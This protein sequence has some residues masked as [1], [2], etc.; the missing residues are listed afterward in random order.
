MMVA[1]LLVLLASCSQFEDIQDQQLAMQ[2]QNNLPVAGFARSEG[3][4]YNPD[5]SVNFG[6]STIKTARLTLKV[7]VFVKA[8][9]D[10]RKYV[11]DKKGFVSR[12]EQKGESEDKLSGTMVLKVPVAEFDATLAFLRALGTVY[13]LNEV[14]EEISDRIV[15]LE[16]RL[17]NSKILEARIREI[18]S[19]QTGNLDQVVQAERELSRVRSEIEEMSGRL[20]N[21]KTRV[22]FATFTIH[23]FVS[24][25][26][27]V[28]TRSWYGP[29][30]QD[31]RDLGFVV[32]GSIGALLTIIVAA[33]PWIFF[34]IFARKLYR[35]IRAKKE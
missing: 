12:N 9:D 19:K 11:G 30:L 16:T 32:A 34:F 21:M 2:E 28:E 5:V 17:K 22:K 33:I 18:L 24:G 13:E 27:D 26:K 14:S 1:I 3:M 31:L 7:S 8:Q 6:S 25:S 35:K 23:L 15:D 20:R 10:I 4:P 29:L